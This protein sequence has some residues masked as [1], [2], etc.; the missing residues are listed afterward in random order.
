M[1]CKLFEVLVEN[2][3]RLLPIFNYE[4]FQK[5][6]NNLRVICDYIA[7]MTDVHATRLYNR[8]FT[9]NTGSMFDR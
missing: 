1:I 4:L 3:K 5:E 8:I 6:E 9:P 2:P 7:G